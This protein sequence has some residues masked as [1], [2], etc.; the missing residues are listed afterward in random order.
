MS[1]ITK[2]IAQTNCNNVN[3]LLNE[4]GSQYEIGLEYPW[5]KYFLG[6]KEK[7]A[8]TW[9]KSYSQC[10]FREI[11]DTANTLYDILY[12]LKQEGLLISKEDQQED[13]NC[14]DQDHDDY[15]MD[16]D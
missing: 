11:N 4:I 14:E 10:G 1:R 7:G 9:I 16:L 13:C 2:H 6:L 8:D 3:K 5:S 15:R 12:Y